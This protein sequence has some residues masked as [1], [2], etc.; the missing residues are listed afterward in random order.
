M[1]TN[2]RAARLTVSKVWKSYRRHPVLRDVSLDVAAGESVAV[3][4]ENG[5]GKST[6]LR[7]CAGL[8]APDDGGVK[9]SGRV[10]YCPQTPGVL[11][12]LTAEEHLVLFGLVA[13]LGRAEALDQGG[14]LLA[15]LGF[16]ADS[17]TVAGALSGGARQKLN[18]ALALLGE[19]DVLLLDEPY[20]GFDRGGYDNFW[21]HL[22]RWS[23]ED[24]VVVVVTHVLAEL[25]RVD[26]VVELGAEPAAD[27][28]QA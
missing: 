21:E 19:P 22:Q 23:A 28:G 16:R 13:G 10:G 20:Q 12:L 4:G 2:S 11:D 26:R 1:A 27:E 3:V 14:A 15:E 17:G 6:L 5:S 24:R 8:L 18:L 7:V 25:S 9:V